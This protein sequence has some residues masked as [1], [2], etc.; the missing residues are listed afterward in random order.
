MSGKIKILIVDDEE[1][2]L[3]ALAKRL[4][5]RDFDVAAFSNGQAAV[6]AARKEEFELVI[7]DL[8]MPGMTGE[9]VLEILKK[10]HPLTEVVI[11]TGHGSIPSAVQCTIS[12]SYNYLQKPCETEELLDVLRS[13][14]QRRVQ[15]KLQIDPE[16]MEN[17]LSVATGESPLGI[18]RRL[19]NMEKAGDGAR[20]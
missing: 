10:E 3:Q 13:A 16:E 15:R 11:L 9:Q 19:K 18:L 12:G 14:Y 1:R 8:K 6:A 7:L 20:S 2:F 5:L 4:Q 17:R